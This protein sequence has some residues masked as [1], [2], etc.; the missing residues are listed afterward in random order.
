MPVE[1]VNK[2]VSDIYID[3]KGLA[4]FKQIKEELEKKLR[5]LVDFQY[6]APVNIE[7]GSKHLTNKQIRE[8]EDILLDYGL[9]LDPKFY[10]MRD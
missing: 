6:G 9:H 5:S 3:L 2:N 7:L 1:T 8:I 4:A 10:T